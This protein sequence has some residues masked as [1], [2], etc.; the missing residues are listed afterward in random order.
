MLYIQQNCIQDNCIHK[1]FTVPCE[2]SKTVAFTSSIIN[3]IIAS[4]FLS[5]VAVKLIFDLLLDQYQIPAV[6]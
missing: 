5:K 4:L 6:Y 2:N 3:N 1:T